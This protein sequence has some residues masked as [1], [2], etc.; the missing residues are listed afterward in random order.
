MSSIFLRNFVKTGIQRL[1]VNL[2]Y[3]GIKIRRRRPYEEQFGIGYDMRHFDGRPRIYLIASTPRS[4]SHFLG[5]ALMETTY[6]GV[7]LEYLNSR[8]LLAW[9]ERFGVWPVDELFQCLF[10]CRTS[11]SGW[12]GMKAHWHQYEQYKEKINVLI[13]GEFEKILFIYRRDLLSQAISYDIAAQTNQ[14]I[15]QSRQQRP[16]VFNYER[17]VEKA[18]MILEENRSWQYWLNQKD[19]AKCTHVVYEDLIKDTQCY[20]LEKARFIDPEFPDRIEPSGMTKRQSGTL[21]KEWRVRVFD[22][23]RPEHSWILEPQSW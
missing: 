3:F 16:A 5:H 10:K 22:M 8:N 13:G 9:R 4:G 1:R 15:S 18:E 17:I 6:F 20:L 2:G 11:Q 23:L 7:P 14:W 12:F 21:S 19:S